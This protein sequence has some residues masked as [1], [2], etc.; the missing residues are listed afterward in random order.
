MTTSKSPLPGSD[1][2]LLARALASEFPF[3]PDYR[4][5]L[6]HPAVRSRAHE[7][8][9]MMSVWMDIRE[10]AVIN[11]AIDKLK[12][13]AKMQLRGKTVRHFEVLFAE[14]PSPVL[15]WYAITEDHNV[16]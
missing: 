2:G 15:G 12:S 10:K 3:Q 5:R 6:R 1:A 14:W 8:Q 4:E 16:E 13:D 9:R 11:T 7:Y